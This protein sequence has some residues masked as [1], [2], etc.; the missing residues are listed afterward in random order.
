MLWRH[1]PTLQTIIWKFTKQ[2]ENSNLAFLVMLWVWINIWDNLEIKLNSYIKQKMKKKKFR[3]QALSQWLSVFRDIFE[4]SLKYF[5][6]GLV[7]FNNSY[8]IIHTNL[9]YYASMRTNIYLLKMS[10]K[11]ISY[12]SN[13]SYMRK[14]STLSNTSYM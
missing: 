1:L 11:L 13:T 3:V 10:F 6:W 4:L 8:D 14:K 7:F 9:L 5:K 12:L 2:S